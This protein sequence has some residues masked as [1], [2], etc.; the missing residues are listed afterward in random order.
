M[1]WPAK[2]ASPWTSERQKFL[3][4]FFACAVLFGAGP[5]HGHRVHRLQVAGIRNQVNIDFRS[6]AGH[7]FAGRAHVILHVAAAQ[8]AARIHIL[9]PGKHF[10]R[11]SL[12]HLHNYVEAAAVAHAHHQIHRAALAGRVQDFIHQ[13]KQSGHPFERKTLGAEIA[14]LQHLLEQ[15]GPDKQVEHAL[16]VHRGLGPFHALLDPAPPLRISNV[17]ELRAHGAAV[18]APRFIGEFACDAQTGM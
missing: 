10:F 16:L 2:A 18:H 8:H 12:G 4:T 13:G 14:L 11:R 6:R 9:K 1:P 17:H 5:A 3:R 7:I 15:V